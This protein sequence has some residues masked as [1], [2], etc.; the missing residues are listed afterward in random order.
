MSIVLISVYCSRITP[1]RITFVT[2]A[3]SESN[4]RRNVKRAAVLA[5]VKYNQL[6]PCIHFLEC[7][8]AVLF[9]VRPTDTANSRAVYHPETFVSPS[10]QQWPTRHTREK[11]DRK[12]TRLN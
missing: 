2:R 8:A 12:S 3:P 7:W 4:R 1:F 6:T 11:R 5:L 10:Q 9:Y